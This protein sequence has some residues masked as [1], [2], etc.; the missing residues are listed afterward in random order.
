MGS[1]PPDW[2][3][4]EVACFVIAVGMVLTGTFATGLLPARL[5]YQVL[6]GSLIVGA[7]LLVGGCLREDN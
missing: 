2:L 4:R 5:P 7:F 6:A 3:D 1:L